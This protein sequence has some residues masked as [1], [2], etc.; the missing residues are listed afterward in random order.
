[1]DIETFFAREA[2]RRDA[3]KSLADCYHPPGEGTGRYLAQLSWAFS[4]LN[5]KAAVHATAMQ[6]TFRQ[7]PLET[8]T[9][10]YSSLFV[11]PYNV[12]A[13]PYGSVYLENGRTVMGESTLDAA[14]RYRQAGL[15]VTVDFKAPADHV[16]AELEFMYLLV[17]QGIA[18]A[19][20]G[21]DLLFEENLE[22]RGAFLV[23]HLGAW[24]DDFCRSVEKSAGTDFY[25]S[26]AAATR[27]FIA[28]EAALFG[29][30]ERGAHEYGAPF[31]STRT[32]SGNP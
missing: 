8:L 18:V 23:I 12:P 25:R 11:G 4:T 32:S 6:E 21:D 9:V 17:F 29:P 1:M 31:S 2:A 24:A 20:E 3:Y 30:H 16:A 14:R 22:R 13:P 19:A 5:S 26:L 27:I 7:A 28:E 15:A 10:D